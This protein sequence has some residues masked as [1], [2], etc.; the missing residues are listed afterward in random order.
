MPAAVP[1]ATLAVTPAMVVQRKESG[2]GG[3]VMTFIDTGGQPI[4]GGLRSL[5]FT[6]V[7]TTVDH[8]K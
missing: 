1:A 6:A 4:F 5:F 3:L 7:S 2:A 8:S